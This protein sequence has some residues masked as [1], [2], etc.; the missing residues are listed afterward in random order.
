M[1]SEWQQTTTNPFL[2][3]HRGFNYRNFIKYFNGA[4]DCGGTAEVSDDS[5]F[6]M[7]RQQNIDG[8]AGTVTNK[9]KNYRNFSKTSKYIAT[10]NLDDGQFYLMNGIL[11]MFDQNRPDLL[12][13]IDINGKNG[14]QISRDMTYL[15]FN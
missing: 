4:T 3:V 10:N 15:R 7:V 2:T 14:D 8:N 5:D 12:I 13:S 9:D 1:L 6:C 11:I